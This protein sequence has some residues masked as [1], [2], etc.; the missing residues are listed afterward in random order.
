MCI[1]FLSQSK[2][3]A[4]LRC[5]AVR[6]LVTDFYIYIIDFFIIEKKEKR[7]SQ[8]KILLRCR[9]TQIRQDVAKASLH[10]TKS[11]LVILRSKSEIKF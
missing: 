3:S 4:L 8:E 5:S 9:M 1:H 10:K 7:R 11:D 2:V 6:R